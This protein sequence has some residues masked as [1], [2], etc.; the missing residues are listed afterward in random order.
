MFTQQELQQML[1]F[2]NKCQLMGNESITHAILLQR[3]NFAL[4]KLNKEKQKTD[5][6]K[7]AK[8]PKDEN[9]K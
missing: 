2:L 7:N 3:V 4:N 1:I 9:K 6:L 8:L 5:L